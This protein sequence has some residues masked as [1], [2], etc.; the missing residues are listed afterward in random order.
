M[1]L[2]IDEFIAKWTIRR[3][4]LVVGRKEVGHWGYAFEGY[5]FVTAP[6]TLS[7]SFPA[8]KR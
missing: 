6:S 2:P 3:W 1:D 5:T 4:G 8:T 7:F